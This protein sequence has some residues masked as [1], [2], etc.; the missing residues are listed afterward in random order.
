MFQ[1]SNISLDSLQK[2]C[3]VESFWHLLNH[4]RSQT[5]EINIKVQY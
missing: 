1:H 4:T 5:N 2:K 3:L